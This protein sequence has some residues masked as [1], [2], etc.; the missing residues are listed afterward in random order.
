MESHAKTTSDMSQEDLVERLRLEE[1]ENAKVDAVAFTQKDG[2]YSY[3]S[4][5][6]VHEQ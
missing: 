1:E 3:S 5:T 4:L 2:K 6:I